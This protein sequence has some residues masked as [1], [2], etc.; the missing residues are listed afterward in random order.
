MFLILYSTPSFTSIASLK[1]SSAPFY[2]LVFL[3]HS[4]NMSY[5]S[6]IPSFGSHLVETVMIIFLFYLSLSIFSLSSGYST[7]DFVIRLYFDT[8]LE[9]I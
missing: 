4:Y 3:F 1:T 5:G 8:L 2:V 6:D 7:L 9:W